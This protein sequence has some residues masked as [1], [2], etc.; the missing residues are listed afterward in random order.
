MSMEEKKEENRR[1]VV[2]TALK[3]FLERGI[4]GV[5]T[6]DIAKASGFTERSVYRY[7]TSRVELVLSASFLFWQRIKGEVEALVFQKEYQG[8]NGIGRI[9]LM[10]EYYSSLFANNPN[11]VKFILGV[12]M[13]LSES[14]VNISMKDRPP[15]SF[16]SDTPLTN[17]IRAGLADG[18]V[19][20][21]I[22]AKEV[23]YLAYDSIL[24]LMQRQVLGA[25]N[26]ESLDAP[27]R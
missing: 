3:L 27:K 5:T 10:L 13:A 2:E 17:A 24:G 26:E 21:A 12:E 22:D 16:D 25:V 20:R 6:K 14:G 1:I 23:Y 11:A 9:R 8:L 7:F 15:G 19:S 4:N 18:S